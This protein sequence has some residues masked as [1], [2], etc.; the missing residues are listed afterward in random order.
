MTLRYVFFVALALLALPT[1]AEARCAAPRLYAELVTPLDA[2][3][4]VGANL[5]VRLRTGHEYGRLPEVA[6]TADDTVTITGLVL[7]ANDTRIAL[8]SEPITGGLVRLVPERP[9]P[10]GTYTLSGFARTDPSSGAS[11]AV[12]HLVTFRGALPAL[13]A[14]VAVTAA[15]HTER[16]LGE[17]R[18]GERTGYR[19]A[20]TLERALPT[21][22]LFAAFRTSSGAVV[23]PRAQGRELVSEGEYGGRHCGDGHVPG[24][25]RASRGVEVSLVMVDA[26]GRVVESTARVRVR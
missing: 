6:R 16:S 5:L 3:V 9:V 20:F 13:P 15:T 24:T 14:P 17:T 18:W 2:P 21:G 7:T 19:T 1:A 22:I 23:V 10:A 26:Y 25:V 11:I 8:R 4:P 12:P